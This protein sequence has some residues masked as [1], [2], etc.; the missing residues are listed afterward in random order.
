M[1]FAAAS[2]VIDAVA[3]D[4][5]DAAQLEVPE[6]TPLL[7]QRRSARNPQGVIIEHND[8]RYLPTEIAFT[9]ENAPNVRA[10]LVRRAQP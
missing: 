10:P 4:G 9:L 8:D 2:H 1:E 5:T 3:A 6:G 7:R